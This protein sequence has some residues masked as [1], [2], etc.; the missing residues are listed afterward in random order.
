MPFNNIQPLAEN[1]TFQTLF[2]RNNQV[3]QRLGELNVG[4]IGVESG[5]SITSPNTIGG[6]T[7]SVDFTKVAGLTGNNILI[8]NSNLPAGLALHSAVGISG[9]NI[10]AC[11][12]STIESCRTF[13]GF[14]SFIGATYYHITTS[15][16]INNTSLTN[17][18]LYYLNNTGNIT[19]TRPTSNNSIVKPVLFHINNTNGGIVLQHNESVINVAQNTRIQSSSRL[20]AEIPSSNLTVGNSIYF[21]KNINSWQKARANA[22]NTSEV[23]GI[24]ESISGIT[25]LIVTHG[26]INIDGSALN[27]VGE[28][29]GI[30]G[31]DIW[32]LS[33][34]ME[35]KLQN[36]G[37]TL[38][39]HIVKPVF[40]Q[41]PH[42]T[43]GIVYNGY[44]VNYSGYFAG[45]SAASGVGGGGGGGGGANPIGLS[46][47]SGITIN[48]DGITYTISTMSNAIS[49]D[50]IKIGELKEV[51]YHGQNRFVF[52]S[53]LS[54]VK[55]F[56]AGWTH[57]NLFIP[58]VLMQLPCNWRYLRDH[59][60][61]E[62]I[63]VEERIDSR[64]NLAGNTNYVSIYG[65][66]D[67]NYISMDGSLYL[68]EAPGIPITNTWK[69]EFT[70]A[71][72]GT[73]NTFT[74]VRIGAEIY[75][76]SSQGGVSAQ[77]Y[78][79][80]SIP[81]DK[82]IES[83]VNSISR[84]QDL[85]NWFPAAE[86]S[87]IAN[88]RTTDE[89]IR[90]ARLL[91]LWFT[92][93]DVQDNPWPLINW[94]NV[95]AVFSDERVAD[96]GQESEFFVPGD[97]NSN[98]SGMGDFGHWNELSG[99]DWGG[100]GIAFANF[101]QALT[102]ESYSNLMVDILT[103]FY[104]PGFMW[105]PNL[106]DQTTT[107]HGFGAQKWTSTHNSSGITAG[108]L[109]KTNSET[110]TVP[111]YSNWMMRDEFKG[112][113]QQWQ[114]VGFIVP[115]QARPHVSSDNIQY[116]SV[117]L[118][119]RRGLLYFYSPYYCVRNSIW[120]KDKICVNNFFNNVSIPYSSDPQDPWRFTHPYNTKAMKW[121]MR[122]GDSSSDKYFTFA[123]SW[124]QLIQGI[125]GIHVPDWSNKPQSDT[126]SGTKNIP[127]PRKLMRLF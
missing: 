14:I 65:L 42:T 112:I 59:Q 9:G 127:A 72:M 44:V 120:D 2:A 56:S 119:D 106:V 63:P 34:S 11:S 60:G 49:N 32:F 23:F 75:D 52:N 95:R 81:L 78:R 5:I 51:A 39:G 4:N 71:L 117:A 6:V 114:E 91:E 96:N 27:D 47:G 126:V 105:Q 25:A 1:D 121:N 111:L 40:Y 69:D 15:G 82:F 104:L 48:Q 68:R 77:A 36:L 85:D 84:I 93:N 58:G 20:I 74:I 102:S 41:F 12:T 3:I 73:G 89:K 35:G 90:W 55:E 101:K 53:W 98:Q 45:G 70:N 38:N 100:S 10:G 110:G 26:S 118:V 80:D 116:S 88:Q 62:E 86:T 92:P 125:V 8:I 97:I 29:G 30:G 54:A 28:N 24:V 107:N 76:A 57:S 122:V 61:S 22:A 33:P 103:S 7:L 50:T 16:K 123:P 21:D 83:G 64:L 87:H 19:S 79:S 46:A 94:A 13:L 18:T 124:N 66:T 43:D 17:N 113:T 109:L 115:R 108:V 99:S 37:P 67:P 31:N